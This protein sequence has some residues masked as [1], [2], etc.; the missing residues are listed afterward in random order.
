MGKVKYSTNGQ[1]IEQAREGSANEDDFASN[2]WGLLLQITNQK[3]TRNVK[4]TIKASDM[5]LLLIELVESFAIAI[6]HP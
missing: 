5:A 2:R 3:C 6:C 1:I 4:M